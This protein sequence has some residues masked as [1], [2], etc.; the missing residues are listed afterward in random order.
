[1]TGRTRISASIDASVA[2]RAARVVAATPGASFSSYV[3]GALA[4]RLEHDQ[5]H[6]A[7]Q[8]LL[9]EYE[10]EHGEITDDEIAATMREVRSSAVVIRPAA[11]DAAIA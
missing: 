5:R 7:W 9:S 3:N 1:M 6:A 10:Q 11:A 2:E 4:A 8:R